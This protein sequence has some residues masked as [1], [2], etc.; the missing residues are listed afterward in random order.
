MAKTILLVDDSPT[1]LSLIQSTLSKAGYDI[2]TATNGEECLEQVNSAPPDLILLDV[3][4]PVMDGYTTLREL[5]YGKNRNATRDIPVVMLT[6]KGRLEDIFY[7]E[8][9]TDFI[10]KSQT[11]F[12]TLPQ[13]IGAVLS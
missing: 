13:K 6:S 1:V 2:Q 4:M 7:L 12:Q 8:G 5:K 3:E 9:A 10:E 11:A